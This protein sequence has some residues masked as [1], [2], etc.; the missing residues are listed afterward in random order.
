MMLMSYFK[1]INALKN[2]EKGKRAFILCNGPSI[3]NHDLSLL[4]NELVIGMNA[5]TLLEKKF[6]FFSD[7][8][9]VSDLRFITHPQKSIWATNE[10]NPLTVRVFR[11]EIK[12]ADTISVDNDTYYVTALKRDGFSPNLS[13]GY[14]FGCTTTMLA[15]QLA[16]FLGVDQV[17]LLGCDLTYSKENPRFYNEDN[18]QLED[19]FTSVQI[20]NIADAASFFEGNGREVFNCN[21]SSLLN[22]YIDFKE[23]ESLF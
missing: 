10:L 1:K 19:S 2:K 12:D 14:F 16:Y 3:N 17:Y 7:Y 20:K 8:Y 5:S 9:V 15:L 22:P 23:F 13:L 4:K 6:D 21:Q 18:P 11:S